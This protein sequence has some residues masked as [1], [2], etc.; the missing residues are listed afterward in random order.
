MKKKVLSLL[1]AATMVLS[2][3]ACGSSSSDKS[4]SSTASATTVNTDTSTLYVN[5]ASE[6]DYLDPALNSS[7]DGAILAVNS[8]VGLLT[9]DENGELTPALASEM[10]TV[11]DDGLT[12]TVHMIESKWSNGDELTANDFVYSWNRAIAAETAADYAYLFDVVARN[13]DGTLAVTADDDYTLTITLTAPC[14]YFNQLLAFPVYMPVHQ[15]SVEAANPDGTTPGAW[16]Q[17][18][19]F[20]SNGAFTLTEWNH[21][22]SMVYTKNE[23]YYD[24]DNVTLESLNYMLS[25]DNT[26]TY[27]AYNSG[28]LDFIDDV[29]TDEISTIS[30]SEEFNVVDQLGTY[31]VAFNV[32]SDLF[33]GMTSDQAIAFRE[34][35][36]LL[37]DRD[38]IAETVGQTGQVAADAFI[39][40]GMEDGNG[41]AYESSYYDADATGSSNADSV[42]EAMEKFEEAGCEVEDNGDGTYTTT[43]NGETISIPYILNEN[44]SHQMIAECIQQD[45]AIAGIEMTI[46]TEDWNVFLQDRKDGNFTFAREGWVAD[47][48]DPINMLEIFSSESGNNDAQLGK[49]DSAAAPEWSAYDELIQQ[50]YAETDTAARAELLHEAEDMLMSTYAVIPIYYYN[51]IYMQKSNVSGIYSTVFGNK[52]FMYATKTAE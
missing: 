35:I 23:N 45:L 27:A 3:A 21:N 26:A 7:V 9:Y 50:I 24:A 38:Y 37:I 29:P 28:D 16:C 5:I 48:D 51:D 4:S 22:E 41:E 15:A 12:Y 31:Y 52:Y 18:A 10:P 40:E 19:G 13:D 44:S 17:E 30:D 1:L 36:S 43:L 14:P 8:F 25:A 42:A 11:S 32:D 20:V 46:S 33:S 49:S 2:L 39:P 47:Y 34:G 6:P